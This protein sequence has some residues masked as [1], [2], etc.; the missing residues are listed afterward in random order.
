MSSTAQARHSPDIALLHD[1]VAIPSLSGQ[2]RAAVEWLCAAMDARGFTT[3]IDAVGNA[4][5]QIGSGQREVVLLGHIDTVP[6]NIPVRVS[7]GQ[8]YGRGAVDA[9]G[10]LATF[11]CAATQAANAGIRL[12]VIGAVGEEADSVGAYYL[13]GQRVAPDFT[14]IGEP[15]GWESVV[16]G[17]KGSMSATYSLRQSGA[18][19][20]APV[21]TAPQV[22]VDFWNRVMRY[23]ATFN[24]DRPAA[25]DRIE[26]KLRAFNT[27]TNGLHEQIELRLGFRLPLDLNGPALTAILQDLA[28]LEA[29]ADEAAAEIE[30]EAQITVAEALPAFR[31]ERTSPLVRPFLPAIRAAG[32][33]PRFKVKTGTAD[34]NIVGPA[35]GCPIVA[36][37]PGDSKLDHTPNE[38]IVLSEYERAI[39][40]LTAALTSLANDVAIPGQPELTTKQ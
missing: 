25:F 7:D 30:A 12:T 38:R 20:A 2:E 16:L 27:T 29:S 4:I 11:V 40:I 37:G 35:W 32:G 18:H 8:L 6:G 28:Q 33:K 15:S 26:P 19:S 13:A 24:A 39:T 36:Y 9:K 3:T 31:S 10:P 22:A 23:A 1:L 21:A 34:M 14:I 17:Y 5:G